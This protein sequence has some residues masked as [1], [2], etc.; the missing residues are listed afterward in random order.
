MNQDVQLFTS[1]V[2]AVFLE[3]SPFLLLGA[4][5]S[6]V[7]EVYLPS[8]RLEKFM[9]R[10]LILGLLFGLSAGMLIPTCEC[11]VVSIARRLLK[12]G[13]P[14]HVAMTYML[15]APV[16]NPLT[17]AAT[18]IAFRGN[19]WM[20]LG[21]IGIVAACASCIGL[22]L[23]RT[24]PVLMMR[25]KETEPDLCDHG[26]TTCSP[27]DVNH[28]PHA[29]LDVAHGCGCSCAVPKGSRLIQVFQH[30]ASEFLD[31][32]TYLILGALAV[33]FFRAILY[34]EWLAFFQDN[35]FL[36][37][38]MMM[39]LAF[40]L[41]ICSQADAFVAASFVTFPVVAQL[42]FVTLGPMVDLK[43]VAMYG[44]VF[45]KHIALTL[46]LVPII[47]IYILSLLLGIVIR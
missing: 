6:S 38:G 36:A 15:S 2:T 24:N 27:A 30:T 42:S 8:D 35:V 13:V 47:L 10:G 40:F 41:S 7:F 46:I 45:R 20:V 17:I 1:T 39:L 12:K 26:H 18:Y 34:Q 4:L 19:M 44:A 37:I 29:H 11:G 5:L 23:A 21:R 31:M 25:G 28:L 32:G 16:I 14:P 43:L 9:P 22:A 3:A 33:G